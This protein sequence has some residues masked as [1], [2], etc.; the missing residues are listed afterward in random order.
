[1]EQRSRFDIIQAAAIRSCCF[2]ADQAWALLRLASRTAVAAFHRH[3]RDRA[4]RLEALTFTAL[5]VIEARERVADA[6]DFT[7][8]AQQVR[9]E[10]D[11]GCVR[12][13]IDQ[14]CA[15]LRVADVEERVNLGGELRALCLVSFGRRRL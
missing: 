14:S 9:R 3:E 7:K 4:R 13:D 6:G 12:E 11:V 10:D 2:T 15:T 8:G 1:M 5:Q